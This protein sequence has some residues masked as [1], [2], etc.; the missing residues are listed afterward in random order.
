MN[1]KTLVRSK[2]VNHYN[3]TFNTKST[4]KQYNIPL[5][6][7][8]TES[9]PIINNNAN[10]LSNQ[11]HSKTNRAS[12]TL[13][14]SSKNGYL[15]SEMVFTEASKDN[16]NPTSH[17]QF[18][19]QTSTTSPLLNQVTSDIF[20]RHKIILKQ[21]PTIPTSPNEFLNFVPDI[22]LIN[23]F[24]VDVLYYSEL[25]KLNHNDN[26]SKPNNRKYISRFCVITK[27]SFKYFAS[28]EKFITLQK[29]ILS[30]DLTHIRQVSL[31]Q[32]ENDIPTAKPTQ[33]P[34]QHHKQFMVNNNPHKKLKIFYNFILL[35]DD[36][37][38][39][40]AS[41]NQE[42]SNKFVSI[43]NYYINDLNNL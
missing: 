39:V 33:P 37:F 24:L 11:K 34:A 42:I 12:Q 20:T 23:N 10:S 3:N 21:S 6:D 32:F 8:N 22:S 7:I 16:L 13:L 17:F 41:E 2:K 36:L 14:T 38:E 26:L 1:L 18:F 4:P 31:F 35:Y 28:R 9:D 43:I 25:Y 29:P 19:R 15:A 27:T 30:I 5:Y 40:F